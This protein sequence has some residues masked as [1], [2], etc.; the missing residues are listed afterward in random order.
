MTPRCIIRVCQQGDLYQSVT[1]D[2]AGFAAGPQF[3]YQ[4]WALF[5]VCACSL[6]WVGYVSDQRTNVI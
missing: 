6:D 3:E 1:R 4:L 2:S 5:C